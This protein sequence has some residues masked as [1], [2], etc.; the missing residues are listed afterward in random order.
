M[1]LGVLGKVHNVHTRSLVSRV[2]AE[3]ASSSRSD[4]AITDVSEYVD[5]ICQL[6]GPTIPVDGDVLAESLGTSTAVGLSS[7]NVAENRAEYG[8]NALPELKQASFLE[9]MVEAAED[10]TLLILLG[11]GFLSLALWAIVDKAQGPGWIDSTAILAAVAVVVLVTA[12]TNYQRD[13]Q[14]S[15]LSK[16][17]GNIAVRLD[18]QDNTCSAWALRVYAAFADASHGRL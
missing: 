6:G 14:F 13:K 1:P 4:A 16:E 10:F 11:S 7:V 8:S 9:L 12:T 2:L 15:K 3:R 17:E 18:S 5:Q